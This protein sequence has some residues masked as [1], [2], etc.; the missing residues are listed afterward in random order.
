MLNTAEII[1]GLI[2]LI[3]VGFAS[4]QKHFWLGLIIPILTSIAFVIILYQELFLLLAI[5]MT[6][7]AATRFAYRVIHA[8]QSKHQL[9]KL[10]KLRVKDLQ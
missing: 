10:D 6:V 8:L 9:S 7:F 5:E 1:W 3:F 4:Y 2:I